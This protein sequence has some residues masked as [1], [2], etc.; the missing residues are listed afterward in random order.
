MP[1]PALPNDRWV[2]IRTRMGGICGSDLNILTLRASPS[3]SPFSSFP[4][5]LGHE[6]VG[7]VTEVGPGVR[8][9]A[10]GARVTANPLLACAARGI[11]PP[12]AACASGDPQRCAH[13]T[14]GDVAPGMLLGTTRD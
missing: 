14:D 13:F 1:S 9:V 6:N 12:C 10:V 2:R 4:F 7:V 8:S 3:T 5:V 11:H